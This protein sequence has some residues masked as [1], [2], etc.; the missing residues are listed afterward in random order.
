MV[1]EADSHMDSEP[2]SSVAQQEEV[3]SCDSVGVVMHL[4]CDPLTHSQNLEKYPASSDEAGELK[5]DSKATFEGGMPP[6]NG[7]EQVLISRGANQEPGLAHSVSTANSREQVALIG[8]FRGGVV[9]GPDSDCSSGRVLEEGGISDGQ[10]CDSVA[11]VHS[12]DTVSEPRNTERDSRKDS[13]DLKKDKLEMASQERLLETELHEDM[14]VESHNEGK[15][16]EVK[17]HDQCK[18]MEVESRDKE[19]ELEVESRDNE[20]EMEVESHDKETEMGIDSKKEPE[21]CDAKQEEG[22]ESHGREVEGKASQSQE[23]QIK[24]QEGKVE[25]FESCD[26][27]TGLFMEAP[28][29]NDIQSSNKHVESSLRLPG[30]QEGDKKEVCKLVQGEEVQSSLNDEKV[31]PSLGV[32][33][34]KQAVESNGRE[35]GSHGKE[36]GSNEVTPHDQV[37]GMNESESISKEAPVFPHTALWSQPESGDKSH[38]PQPVDYLC[39]DKEVNSLLSHNK[40]IEQDKTVQSHGKDECHDKDLVESCDKGHD[41]KCDELHE[42]KQDK[43]VEFNDKTH[44]NE[45]AQSQELD[46]QNE[47]EPDKDI[48][49]RPEGYKQVTLGMEGEMQYPNQLAPHEQMESHDNEILSNEGPQNI[50]QT[51][52]GNKEMEND[53]RSVESSHG[54]EDNSHD[55]Q[56]VPSFES[57][58]LSVVTK[59]VS[60]DTDRQMQDLSGGGSTHEAQQE[61][62]FD[63]EFPNSSESNDGDI[64]LPESHDPLPGSH[65]P[66]I[67]E[68]LD[69][70]AIDPHPESHDHLPGSH[71]PVMTESL[72][73]MAIG[74]PPESHDPVPTWSHPESHDP[75]LTGSHDSPPE[76]HDRIITSPEG[77]PGGVSITSADRGT[78][79]HGD[80]VASVDPPHEVSETSMETAETAGEVRE[81]LGDGVKGD[82]ET[83]ARLVPSVAQA[84]ASSHEPGSMVEDAREKKSATLGQ[85]SSLP[86][87]EAPPDGGVTTEEAKVFFCEAISEEAQEPQRPVGSCDESPDHEEKSHDQSVMSGENPNE[88]PTLKEAKACDWPCTNEA[89]L[90]NQPTMADAKSHDQPTITGVEST[91]ES[92]DQP[93]LTVVESH[94]RQTLDM[95]SVNDA[96]SHD[97]SAVSELRS[98]DQLAENDET[99][100]DMFPKNALGQLLVMSEVKSHDKP[101]END[102]MSQD[103]TNDAGSHAVYDQSGQEKANLPDPLTTKDLCEKSHD[104]RN[105]AER[106]SCDTKQELRENESNPQFDSEV[107]NKNEE[108][109]RGAAHPNQSSDKRDSTSVEAIIDTKDSVLVDQSQ[110]AASS[111]TEG[112]PR[113]IGDQ[114]VQ[115][116][117]MSLDPPSQHLSF[118]KSRDGEMKS[119]DCEP[120]SPDSKQKSRK[121]RQRSSE[122]E[123]KSDAISR[124]DSGRETK[125][126]P[127]LHLGDDE[128]CINSS[129]VTSETQLYAPIDDK[130]EAERGKEEKLCAV[131]STAGDS[132]SC[133]ENEGISCEAEAR[134]DVGV[135]DKPRESAENVEF[136]AASNRVVSLATKLLEKWEG[137]KEVFRIPKRTQS[138][139]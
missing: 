97:E 37:E 79:S 138:V 16:M 106:E 62:S 96:R 66:V 98:H 26:N 24:S 112:R 36:S 74:P 49:S 33:G 10:S 35:V 29:N 18:E 123:V 34:N 116:E 127:E 90:H 2:S 135:A 130:D 131:K 45:Q 84:Q 48:E 58:D 1:T 53:N 139:R 102:A 57:H 65:D 81:E 56:M 129:K 126:A 128:K 31:K 117:Q 73:P 14:E 76:A 13:H 110:V 108:S 100:H 121:S 71:D 5:P 4:S 83:P 22:V 63:A 115:N 61:P 111:T 104:I 122:Y 38:D 39:G 46:T 101:T 25:T 7:S 120:K 80:H 118:S 77:L 105:E 72:D 69:P 6:S 125:T 9:L 44:G 12:T 68:S 54:M 114:P 95:V 113:D 19:T 20:T 41:N 67:T 89:E 43:T 23:C 107:Q 137:L 82:G 8:A 52:S 136:V 78:E 28:G 93:M 124:H 92:H 50:P 109:S 133:E 134:Q 27:V 87:T 3:G 11:G 70:M 15:E 88:Q 86:L 30:E 32:T 42:N 60:H 64:C 51:E 119:L 59:Q 55:Q 132:T 75:V 94:D 47:Q 17:S 91:L 85:T 99:S 103:P 40:K 21:L